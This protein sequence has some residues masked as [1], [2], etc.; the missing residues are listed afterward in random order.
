MCWLDAKKGGAIYRATA[1]E[2]SILSRCFSK[3][4][5]WPIK[6]TIANVSILI[7]SLADSYTNRNTPKK[8]RGD[9]GYWLLLC[10]AKNREGAMKYH[11][12]TSDERYT[13]SLLRKEGYC[14]AS[15]ARILGRHRCTIGREI[16]RNSC[17][18]DGHYRHSKA[19]ER[20]NGRRRSSRRGKHH[21]EAQY[22][23]VNALL[24]L[25]WSPEQISG[26]LRRTGQFQISHETIYRHVWADQ[27]NGGD[28][29]M[30]L[31]GSQKKR[32]KRYRSADS[33]GKLA[34]KRMIDTRP[35]SVE[36]RRHLGHWEIDTVMGKGE[37]DC[38][39][40]IVERKSGYLLVGKLPNR[41]KDELNMRVIA[42]IRRLPSAF[43]T[44]TADNG[45]EFHGYRQIEAATGAI[46]YFATPHHSWERGTNENT[47]GLL[48]QYLPKGTSMAHIT[49][50]DCDEI[51]HRLNTRPRKRHG[52]K[53]PEECFYDL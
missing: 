46:F 4:F 51:A 42:L 26:H 22:R 31:R 6:P 34:D 24:V 45:T 15:I 27:R 37:K 11:Q 25:K 52:Y 9:L 5:F 41:T 7:K 30:H 2:F 23:I 12:L 53:T 20:T 8:K 17:I 50:R 35:P 39:V 48:R 49:Q 19:Q 36:T 21:T 1:F 40:T 47:N 38:V 33:R 32:R 18:Y 3:L 10:S 28:L 16:A 13:I 44:I 14:P 43:K 29:H